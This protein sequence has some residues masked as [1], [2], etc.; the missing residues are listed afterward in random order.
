VDANGTRFQL[1]LGRDDWASCAALGRTLA[2]HWRQDSPPAADA[3]GLEWNGERAELTLQTRLFKFVAA[4]GDSAPALDNRRGAARDRYG[5]W[6]WV[7]ETSLRVRVR[8]HGGGPA[9]D[10]WTPAMAGRCDCEPGFGEFRPAAEPPPPEPL[11]LGGLAITEDHYL[12]VGTLRPAGLLVFDLHA[13]GEPRQLLW[14][15]EVPFAP[16]DMAARPGGGVWILDRNNRRYWALDRHFQVT[17]PARPA[18]VVEEAEPDDFQPLA[19]GEKRGT[20]RRLFPRAFALD[21]ASPLELIDPISIESLPDGTVLVLEHDARADFSRVFRYRF[22]ERVGRPV[23]TEVMRARVEE[24]EDEDFRLAGYD[25][26]F[27]PEH[28]GA[29]GRT[30]GDRLYVAASEGNQSFAFGLSLQGEQLVLE[31]VTEYLPMRLFGGKALVGDGEGVYYDFGES[32]IPLTEQ[33]RPRY[34]TEAVFTTPVFDSNEPDCVWHRLMI[35]GCLPPETRVEIRSRAANDPDDLQAT[36]WRAEPSPYLRGDGS[37]LPY[38]PRPFSGRA[39]GAREA[40]A[41]TWELLFQRAKGRHLQLE[42]RLAGNERTSPRLR[43]M[44]VYYPRFSY[45]AQ[46]LPAVYREE[47]QSA[48]FLER[49]LANL[50]GAYTTLEDRIAAV[51]ILF[52]VR[53][54]PAETLEWLAGWFGVALDPAWDEEKRRVFIRRAMD[55]FQYRGTIH[56][57]KMALHLALDPCADESVFDPP[58]F[59]RVRAHGVRVVEKF[60]TRRTPG[61]VFG[62]PTELSGPRSVALT[63]RWQPQQGGTNLSGRYAQFR[64]R[65]GATGPAPTSFPLVAPGDAADAPRWRQFSEESLGF[66]PSGA[67]SAERALW[68]TFL[69]PRYT[70][71]AALNAAHATAH[72]SFASVPLPRDLPQRAQARADWEEFMLRYRP[73]T[74]ITPER[75]HWQDFLA[76][77]YGSAAALRRAHATRWTAFELIPLFDELPPDGNALQD[78]YQ[79][80]AVAIRMR[81]KAH[82]FTVLLPVP[83]GAAL[84]T[85]E[86]LRRL[87]LA[88]RI[89]NLEKPA[90]TTFDVKYYWALFRVGEARLGEDSLVNQEGSRAPQLAPTMILGEGHVGEGHIAAR[91]PE[92]ERDRAVLGRDPLLNP[93]QE[94][95]S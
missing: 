38:L 47:E 59:P 9:A 13:G 90:H 42:I 1:L 43:A 58:P 54:A 80:E 85:D 6:Y 57:L 73:A 39:A 41:G 27:V 67:P 34:A 83:P 30:V 31:P 26:A 53:S 40:G 95:K 37:E 44:R 20:G 61:V 76:R 77:R 89:V 52:D 25:L 78:W 10:F 28:V 22:A 86:Q 24:G 92:G 87:E 45:L 33:R 32:W 75:T 79:F 48:S 69:R 4:R 74:G 94:T 62:D 23:S 50:E 5:N 55:F 68:Q 3:S 64:A 7:D 63:S 15:V 66:V 16:F 11:P 65:D 36:A 56:G 19:G 81:A 17:D 91:P 51:Q 60:L 35:D 82:Q 18:A 29:D 14:P 2:A 8:S 21:L 70:S 93:R 84:H 49:F 46:Y 72:N 88:T 12:V 71:V